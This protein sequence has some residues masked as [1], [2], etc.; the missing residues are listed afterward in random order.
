M[1]L[2]EAVLLPCSQTSLWDEV[3]VEAAGAWEQKGVPCCRRE[4]RNEAVLDQA[5]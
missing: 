5:S 2:S 4:R 3:V 1:V